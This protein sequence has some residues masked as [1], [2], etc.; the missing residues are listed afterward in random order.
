MEITLYFLRV[1]S[2]Y[3]LIL[4]PFQSQNTPSLAPACLI[5]FLRPS[6]RLQTLSMHEIEVLEN[7]LQKRGNSAEVMGYSFIVI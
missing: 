2:P 1:C 7:P 4:P 3:T 5:I 6:S